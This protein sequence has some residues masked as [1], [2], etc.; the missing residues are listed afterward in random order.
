MDTCDTETKNEVLDSLNRQ[1]YLSFA[2]LGLTVLCGICRVALMS[3]RDKWPLLANLFTGFGIVK[4]LAGVVLI[5]TMPSAGACDKINVSRFYIYPG[6]CIAI[7][8]MW[9]GRAHVLKK[10]IARGPS[11]LPTAVAHP[12]TPVVPVV[13]AVPYVGKGGPGSE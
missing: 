11:L 9:I 5:A 4:I 12:G 7:G 1:Q 3:N 6:I 2:A 10:L 13:H 8:A